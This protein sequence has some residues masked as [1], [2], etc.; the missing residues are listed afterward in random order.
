MSIGVVG[1]TGNVGSELIK[2]LSKQEGISL[3]A[4]VRDLDKAKKMDWK[5]VQ[6]HP[7][8]FSV[9]DTN[10]FQ[11]IDKLFWLIPNNIA[12]EKEWLEIIKASPVK[13]IVLLSSI[14]PDV[15]EMRK[16]EMLVE[17][18]EIHYTIL[19]PN[20]FMQNFNT[21]EKETIIKNSAFY[22]PAGLGKTS[23][24]DVRDIAEAAASVLLNDNHINKM[25]TLTGDET[26]SYYQVAVILSKA[27][28]RSIYYVDTFKHPEHESSQNKNEAILQKFFAGVRSGLFAEVTQDLSLLIKRKAITFN[29]YANDY[30]SWN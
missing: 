3:H 22:Y 13:H 14:F 6:L 17:Q 23:F 12:P 28:G 27:C 20:T 8:D 26:L 19:R 24:I 5:E 4:F 25:Y 11:H 9:L 1:A 29:Q 16:S 30:W 2:I 10:A 18:S 21:D 7:F 15:F